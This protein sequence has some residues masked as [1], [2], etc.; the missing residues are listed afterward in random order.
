MLNGWFSLSFGV[1]VVL[2]YYARFYYCDV[3]LGCC[4]NNRCNS[5]VPL[6]KGN[7]MFQYYLCVDDQFCFKPVCFGIKYFSIGEKLGQPKTFSIDHVKQLSSTRTFFSLLPT[8]LLE[9]YQHHLETF[10]LWHI[11]FWWEIILREAF[12]ISLANS[13]T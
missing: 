13:Q 6:W 8:I 1:G 11:W 3:C 12:L 7:V 4:S 2:M 5:W 10:L 9:A